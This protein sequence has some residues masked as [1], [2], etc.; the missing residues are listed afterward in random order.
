VKIDY[1]NISETYDNH[2]SWG[3]SEI[4]Q[5][6]W[7]GKIEP[8]M[9]I[10]DLGCGTGNLSAQLLE[11]IPVE[12]IGI[13]RSILMLDKASRKSL[14]VLCAD[15]DRDLLPLK[16]SSF[17]LIIGAF[18]IHHIKHINALIKECYRVLKDGA[19]ILITSSHDQIDDLHPIIKDFFP[20][21]IEMDKRRFPEVTKLD[22][23]FENA[24]FKSIRHE[25][26][27][28]SGI[29]IDMDYLEKVKNRYVSTFHLL[30]ED[31]FKAGVEKL[32]VF[33]RNTTEPVYREWRGTMIYGEKH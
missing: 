10:L 18:V 24:G 9:K 3:H 15:A 17:D 33:V 6:I 32:A 20:S 12:M 21:L 27:I 31:E 26:L 16:D 4:L 19:L 23:F 29:P 5:L 30:P 7:F 2:R 11:F 8:G 22:Y 13:D 1:N 14:Q 25:E 28:I